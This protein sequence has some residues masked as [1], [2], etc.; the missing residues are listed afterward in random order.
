MAAR[1]AA[2]D[3]RVEVAPGT[4]GVKFD[5]DYNGNAAVVKRYIPLPSGQESPLKKH[6]QI[7]YVLVSVNDK[8]VATM[9][10]KDV[11]RAMK[12]E[13]N[14]RRTLIFRE[15]SVHYANRDLKKSAIKKTDSADLDIEVT[16]VRLNRDGSKQF[17]EYEVLCTLRKRTNMT[18]NNL[19][20][21]GVWRRYSAFGALSVALKAQYGWQMQEAKFPPKKTFGAMEPS[22]LEQ[23]RRGL[24]LYMHFITQI[25]N[26]TDFSKEHLSSTELKRF[27]DY[28]A[29]MEKCGIKALLDQEKEDAAKA[30][31]QI[32][33]KTKKSRRGSASH[34]PSSSGAGNGREND[35]SESTS[36][37]SRSKGK[38]RTGRRRKKTVTERVAAAR[39]NRPPSSASVSKSGAAPESNCEKPAPPKSE[40]AG[41]DAPAESSEDALVV[42]LGPEYDMFKKMLKMGLPEGAVRQK[43]SLAGV[44]PAPL[45]S[46]GSGGSNSAPPP[47]R[48]MPPPASK[49]A[50]RP[51]PP[52]PKTPPP[53]PAG[54]VTN[55][56]PNRGG[57]LEAI[58]KGKMLKKTETVEKGAS[59]GDS[60][61]DDDDA[62]NSGGGG[63]GM[64]AE[65][66]R[67]A[68]ARRARAN[69]D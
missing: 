38:G 15:S 56:N 61:S 62:G 66:M 69:G 24:D 10:H 8:N 37:S 36:K 9:K 40:D 60:G 20:Q 6:V 52:M 16:Q 67:K 68:Q 57:L 1:G 12:K 58:R 46:N 5:P 11:L 13:L 7:G 14:H 39:G 50:P 55:P 34:K 42:A 64:M 54:V 17:A 47:P 53:M 43:M 49:S 65:M 35:S 26:V 51:P 45:F 63:G 4:L 33:A 18:K 21:W 22:F 27:V 28:D 32:K 30:S 59:V 48:A 3:V 25:R 31:S 23:R 44:D 41:A 29:G 19:F 2:R